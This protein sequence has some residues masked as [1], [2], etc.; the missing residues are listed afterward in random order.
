MQ[1]TYVKWLRYTLIGGLFLSLLI[2]FI[3]A[4]G[5]LFPNMFFP[6]VTGKNFAFRILVDLLLG[7]YVLLALREP[8]YRPRF[9]WTLA[10]VGAFALW[11]GIADIF[12]SVDPIK[13][14]WSNF[15]RME[16]YITV[17]H[18]LAYFV[19]VSAVLSAEKLWTWFLRLSVSASVVMSS[20][21]LLQLAGKIAI[22]QGSTRLDGTLGNAIYLA[23]YMLFNIFF[24]LILLYRDWDNKVLRWFYAA[25]LVLDTFVLFGTETRGTIIGLIGGLVI[26]CVYLL[27]A[28][29]GD[30][31]WKKLR[32]I[33]MGTLAALVVLVL[34]FIVL[35]NIPAIQSAPAFGRLASISLQDKTT[36]A[37]FMVW[38]MAWDGF[39]EK[40]I[41]GWGQENFNYVFNKYYNPAMYAQEQWFDRAHDAFLDWLTAAGA[42]GFLLFIS[43]FCAS[44][45]AFWR[46][47]ALDVPERAILL[48]LLAGFAFHELFVFDNIVSNIQFFTVLALAHGLS[49][50]EVP[51]RVWLARPLSEKGMAIAAPVVIAAILGGTWWLNAGGIANAKNLLAAIEVRNPRTGAQID[52]NDNLAA[53]K[54]VIGGAPI[55]RQEAAEQLT[56]FAPL[57]AQSSSA[58]PEL[59]QEFYSAALSAITQMTEERKGD[60]RLEL[61]LGAFFDQF[62]QY[63]EALQHL[64]LAHQLSPNKQQILFETG[65]NNLLRSGNMT[66]ALSVLKE[67]FMLDTSYDAAR[68]HYTTALYAAGQSAQADALILER[69]GTLTPDNTTLLQSYYNGKQY[70]R[71]KVILNNR[72]EVDPNYGPSWVQ[73][74][75]VYY[76][77]GDKQGAIAVL[78]RGVAKNPAL[79]AQFN[80]II[81]QVENEK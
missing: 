16:G 38:N 45:L 13:S 78:K 73:L 8:R 35:R 1:N 4:N 20:Y 2:P 68:F 57:V 48:G 17:L 6:F 31:R 74:A 49:Q 54:A 81:K 70:G 62:G 15:E 33:A 51:G 43:L 64:T 56:Q 29:S 21:G 3:I 66:D 5:Q 25:A 37:R 41:T 34:G 61:F 58:S 12:F 63:P 80:E 42:P 76:G 28:G 65:V 71:A 24:A 39:T 10:A 36:M 52:L 72:L 60:A 79:A 23:V 14:F 30:A 46:S 50:R 59:K 55:G 44:A 27:F 19:V 75:S 26:A 67:A 47:R 22:D 77:E 40:P 9:S 53:F 32:Q 69:F 18:L 11:V 7:A